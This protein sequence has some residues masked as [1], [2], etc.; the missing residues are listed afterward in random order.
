VAD[1][2]GE[3]RQRG[4]GADQLAAGALDV[5]QRVVQQPGVP[6]QLQ[7]VDDHPGQLVQ[8]LPLLVGEFADG[9][10]EHA[11]RAEYVPIRGS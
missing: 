3:V 7:Y 11:Q 6:V 8:T 9:L 4:V 10:V 2:A 1:L 5:E